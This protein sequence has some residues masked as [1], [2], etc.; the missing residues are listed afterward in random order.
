MKNPTSRAK[1]Q[2]ALYHLC[3]KQTRAV[4]SGFRKPEKANKSFAL[5]IDYKLM[6]ILRCEWIFKALLFCFFLVLP[7]AGRGEKDPRACRDGRGTFF[8]TTLTSS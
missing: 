3:S 4:V 7:S 8:H 6:Q 5:P 1:Y 2:R